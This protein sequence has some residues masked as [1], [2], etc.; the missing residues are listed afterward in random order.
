MR[1]SSSFTH[2]MKSEPLALNNS[3]DALSHL[4]IEL[5]FRII[6]FS[7]SDTRAICKLSAV[8]RAWR[9]TIRNSNPWKRMCEQRRYIIASSSPY[10][11]LQSPPWSLSQDNLVDQMSELQAVT[12]TNPRDTRPHLVAEREIDSRIMPLQSLPTLSLSSTS[13][14][15]WKSFFVNRWTHENNRSRGNCIVRGVNVQYGSMSCMQ[16]SFKL[17]VLCTYLT[18]RAFILPS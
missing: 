18:Y 13:A 14:D 15:S 5:I 8:S 3:N 12:P 4:P 9:S 2:L 6:E 16:V 7:S 10:A 11:P 1:T 17:I